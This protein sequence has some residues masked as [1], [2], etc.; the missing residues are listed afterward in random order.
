ML[1]QL[2]EKEINLF[3]SFFKQECQIFVGSSFLKSDS[4]FCKL[5]NYSRK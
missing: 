3:Q 2:V 1:Q 4:D 5:N